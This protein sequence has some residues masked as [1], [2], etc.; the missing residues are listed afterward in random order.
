M[1]ERVATGTMLHMLQV[2]HQ[3]PDSVTRT[4]TARLRLVG[5]RG[6]DQHRNVP[7]AGCLFSCLSACA[8]QFV[9]VFPVAPVSM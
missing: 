8:T 5:H 1:T 6:S 3:G 9:P 4:S 2:K 7:G